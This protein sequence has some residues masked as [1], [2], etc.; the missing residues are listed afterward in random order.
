MYHHQVFYLFKRLDID[1]YKFAEAVSYSET[2]S[3]KMYHYKDVANYIDTQISLR[4]S[5][6]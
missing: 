5:K 2:K 6:N 4:E 3:G 1:Y